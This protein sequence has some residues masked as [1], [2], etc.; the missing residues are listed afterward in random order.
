MKQEIELVVKF[1]RAD[2]SLAIQWNGR[3]YQNKILDF[4]AGD[5]VFAFTKL[6]GDPTPHPKLRLKWSGPYVFIDTVGET[7]ATISTIPSRRNLAP[8]KAKTF[9]LHQTKLRYYQSGDSKA[10]YCDPGDLPSFDHNDWLEAETAKS[11]CF[12]DV[13][14]A[15]VER[16]GVDSWALKPTAPPPQGG[17]G[18]KA[19]GSCPQSQAMPQLRELALANCIQAR[20]PCQ[21]TLPRST[22]HRWPHRPR[23]LRRSRRSAVQPCRQP[24]RMARSNPRPQPQTTER[25]G[26]VS[27]IRTTA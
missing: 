18:S 19:G 5:L 3:Y 12:D 10:P 22:R 15:H 23:P 24:Q 27:A 26:T 25:P 11:T 14:S 4:V 8:W 1:A 21:P 6:R 7:M 13:T 20:L 16:L 17:A 9:M 2:N